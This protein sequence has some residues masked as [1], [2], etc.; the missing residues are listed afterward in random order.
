MNHRA[1]LINNFHPQ[2]FV[3]VMGTGIS[4]VALHTFPYPGFWLTVCSYIMAAICLALFV[5]LNVIMVIY[6]VND[7]HR[8]RLLLLDHSKSLYFGC[9]CMGFSTIISSLHNITNQ[10]WA[11]FVYVLWLVNIGMALFAAWIV[12]FIIQWKLKITTLQLDLTFLLGVVSLVVVGSTGGVI[13]PLLPETLKLS[14]IVISWLC[15]CNGVSLV[16]WYLTLYYWRLYVH[17]IA[18]AHNSGLS[19]ILPIG[20]CG[21]SSYGVMVILNNLK[22]YITRHPAQNIHVENA[23]LVVGEAI[24]YFGFFLGLFLVSNGYYFTFKAVFNISATGLKGY[25]RGWWS[26]TFPLATMSLANHLLYEYYGQKTF[27]IICAIYSASAILITVISLIG[28]LVFEFPYR[29]LQSLD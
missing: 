1:I 10:R 25:T 2:W 23:N 6:I 15:W 21:Q 11:I 29:N 12:L 3:T 24:K 17:K 20:F 13:Y 7:R 14:N 28:S 5:F 9:Y 4:S 26:G 16:C 22:D 18:L 27:K 8:A 19:A